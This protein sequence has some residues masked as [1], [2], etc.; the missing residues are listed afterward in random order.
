MQQ[1]AFR[2]AFGKIFC[3]LSQICDKATLSRFKKKLK[4]TFFSTTTATPT[5]RATLFARQSQWLNFMT[6]KHECWQ[7]LLCARCMYILIPRETVSSPLLTP[8]SNLLASFLGL[9]GRTKCRVLFRHPSVWC[10]RCLQRWT[11]WLFVMAIFAYPSDRLPF[12]GVGSK[13]VFLRENGG[14]N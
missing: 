6:T 5:R 4:K 11:A 13:H 1:Y 2:V 14:T 7:K 8:T 3:K 9:G 12:G 10:L